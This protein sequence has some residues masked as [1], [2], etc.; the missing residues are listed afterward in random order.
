MS[1]NPMSENPMSEEEKKQKTE[2]RLEQ[3]RYLQRRVKLYP[4]LLE[5]RDKIYQITLKEFKPLGITLNSDYN[6]INVMD[7]K[8]NPH[9]IIEYSKLVKFS[10][11]SREVMLEHLIGEDLITAFRTFKSDMQKN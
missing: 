1:E 10:N 2:E 5:N 7:T 9:N 11:G 6:Y 3:A 8:P 4:E